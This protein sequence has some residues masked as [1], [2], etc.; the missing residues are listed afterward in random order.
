MIGVNRKPINASVVSETLR[1]PILAAQLA[2]AG[3]VMVRSPE[4]KPSN[5]ATASGMHSP[6]GNPR[7]KD[8]Y[9]R[10]FGLPRVV[11]STAA[12]LGGPLFQAGS[13]SQQAAEV[14]LEFTQDMAGGGESQ[15]GGAQH[16]P[17]APGA[18][19][20]GVPGGGDDARSHRT[21]DIG[22]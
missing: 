2:A 19:S 18:V 1:I 9:I 13:M 5:N 15:L 4:I 7:S 11:V 6:F 3:A 8:S 12:T 10:R 20:V 16:E 21:H 14:R 22:V 17:H